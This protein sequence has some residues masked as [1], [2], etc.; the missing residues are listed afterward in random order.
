MI[1]C[2]QWP[3]TI[4]WVGFAWA[5]AGGYAAWRFTGG[6]HMSEREEER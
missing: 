5:F 2:S 4:M 1:A 3:A 6:R